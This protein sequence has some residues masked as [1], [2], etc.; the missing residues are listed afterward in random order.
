MP[1]VIVVHWSEERRATFQEVV[2]AVAASTPAEMENQ[3]RY[4]PL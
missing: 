1:G 4:L 2:L 3:V